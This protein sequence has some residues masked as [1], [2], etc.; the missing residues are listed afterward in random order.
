MGGRVSFRKTQ[1][2]SERHCVKGQKI[3]MLKLLFEV[4][5]QF[6]GLL[7]S[8]GFKEKSCVTNGKCGIIHPP[9]ECGKKKTELNLDRRIGNIS[10][11]RLKENTSEQPEVKKS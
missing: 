3:S 2:L 8:R 11:T 7:K 10:T 9:K 6:F 1:C 5:I 4:K